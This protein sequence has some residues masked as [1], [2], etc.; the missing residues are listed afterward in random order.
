MERAGGEYCLDFLTGCQYL[1]FLKINFDN[2][3]SRVENRRWI[4][5]PPYP[6]PLAGGR[7]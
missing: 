3:F 6:L 5:T 4:N 1:P 7:G 2:L